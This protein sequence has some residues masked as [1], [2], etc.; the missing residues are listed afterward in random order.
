MRFIVG[1]II[2]LCILLVNFSLLT[3]FSV[4]MGNLEPTNTSRMGVYIYLC[5]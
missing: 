5:H 1:I 4:S 3:F 2:G